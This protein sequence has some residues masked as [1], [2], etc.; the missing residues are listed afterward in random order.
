M[1]RV[2]RR[3]DKLELALGI[4]DRFPP[5]EHRIRFIDSDGSVASTLVISDRRWEW[6]DNEVPEGNGKEAE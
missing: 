1:L 2:H 4:S 5:V 6:I 3:I